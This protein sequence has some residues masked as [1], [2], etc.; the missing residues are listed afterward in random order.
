MPLRTLLVCLTSVEHSETL[1]KAA[2][3]LARRQ[4][5]HLI[6]LHATEA[7]LVYPGIAVHIPD[8]AFAE[9]SKSQKAVSDEIAAVFA[10][11]T[12]PET[13]PS[14][15]RV[16]KA[17]T[18]SATERLVESARAADLVVMAQEDRDLDRQDLRNS[19]IQVIR[20]SGRPVL[21]VPH[22]YEG[23]DVGSRIMLGWSDTREAARAAHDMLLVTED[24]A[25][26]TILRV[27]ERP[28]DT[29][30]DFDAIDLA[31]SLARHGLVTTLAT[32]NPVGLSIA[33]ALNKAAF[34][35]GA[36]LIVT[37]ALGHSRAYDFVLGAT[38]FAL[39]RD[40]KL[41]VLF[42]K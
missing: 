12:D 26:V 29:L 42:S 36:D 34:E 11:Y 13:F 8:E 22:D 28:A 40:A 17:E 14:E 35:D 21:V 6:G 24:G 39:L 4:N 18:S 10:R 7:L 31:G 9:I 38:T 5:A 25:A 32:R 20:G 33:D 16:V 19:Q 23:P 1:M 41:P 37:G 30:T 27:A 2:V 15:F 3:A